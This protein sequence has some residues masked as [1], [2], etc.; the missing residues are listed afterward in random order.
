MVRAAGG[1]LWR[2]AATSGVEVALIHRP[3]YDD[4]SLPKGKLEDG[5][6]LAAA[7]VREIAEETGFPP[8]LGRRLPTIQYP[9]RENGSKQVDHFSARAVGGEFAPNDEVDELRWLPIAEASGALSYHGDRR[10]LRA[11]AALPADLATLLLVRHAKAGSRADFSG[12]DDLRP[13]SAAGLAQAE[14]LREMLPLFAPTVVH[15]APL[16]RCKQTI[17]AIAA[18]LGIGVA[19]EPSLSEERYWRDRDAGTRRLCRIAAAGG[20][21]LVC[22]QGGVIPDLLARLGDSLDLGEIRSKKGSLWVLSFAPGTGPMC[23]V[24]ADYYPS[25]LPPPRM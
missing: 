4:W 18:D 12:E 21:P 13:L 6:T 19:D 10:V 25:A 17:A 1:V 15:S 11:F 23:L 5:E 14:A 9:L 8:V 16:P 7:A 3:R 22:S 20:T 2:F 24:A